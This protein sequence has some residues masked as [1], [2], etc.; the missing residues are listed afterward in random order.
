LKRITLL[1][2]VLS[3]GLTSCR[4]NVEPHDWDHDGVSD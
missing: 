1:T 2:L 4:E 3:L